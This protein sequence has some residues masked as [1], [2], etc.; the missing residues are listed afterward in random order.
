MPPK[1]RQMAVKAVA[2]FLRS[3][4]G[5]GFAKQ[6]EFEAIGEVGE[7]TGVRSFLVNDWDDVDEKWLR[8]V[9]TWR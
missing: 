1:N 9:R 2:S 6:L 4:A 8:G 5:G 7:N 3:A